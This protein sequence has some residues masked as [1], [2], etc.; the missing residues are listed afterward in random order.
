MTVQVI[1]DDDD[2]KQYTRQSNGYQTNELLLASYSVKQ[3]SQHF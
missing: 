3:K 1:S 2:D